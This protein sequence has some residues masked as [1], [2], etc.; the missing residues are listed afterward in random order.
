MVKLFGDEILIEAAGAK[1]AK[2]LGIEC[3][4]ARELGEMD[5][6]LKDKKKGDKSRDGDTPC[7]QTIKGFC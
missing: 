7:G 5:S 4:R 2:W 3:L 6:L 1:C